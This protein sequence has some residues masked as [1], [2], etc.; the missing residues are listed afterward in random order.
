MAISSRVFAGALAS[1]SGF[2]FKVTISILL[3]TFS[4]AIKVPA[5]S[6]CRLLLT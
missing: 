2:L 5:A 3:S 6:D 4:A 1:G